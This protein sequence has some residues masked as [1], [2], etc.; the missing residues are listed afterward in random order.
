[1]GEI[2]F[3]VWNF[4]TKKFDDSKLNWLRICDGRYFYGNADMAGYPILFLQ[5]SGFQAN[6]V[7]LFEGDIIENDREWW[8]IK[9]EE[10][11]FICDPIMDGNVILDLS[12]LAGSS[13][14]WVQGNIYENP[15]LLEKP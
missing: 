11:R 6:G 12:E 15:E 14:T 7:E 8:Q 9:F 13:E 1:M 10:G 4:A 2:K 5:H 3:K